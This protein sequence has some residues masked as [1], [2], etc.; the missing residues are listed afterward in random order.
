MYCIGIGA[1]CTAV[2][3]VVILFWTALDILSAIYTLADIYWSG[4]MYCPVKAARTEVSYIQCR[5]TAQH[6]ERRRSYHI[7]YFPTCGIMITHLL[8]LL[9]N[10]W[11]SKARE[12][13]NT[14]D[15]PGRS[16]RKHPVSNL[17]S[18][19]QNPRTIFTCNVHCFRAKNITRPVNI[20]AIQSKNVCVLQF[21]KIE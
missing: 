16:N 13:V 1:T 7:S 5:A 20:S 2:H 11:G 3:I 12:I 9:N 10:Y 15:I 19:R 18:C 4:N 8:T 17:T 6:I 21:V 14:Q